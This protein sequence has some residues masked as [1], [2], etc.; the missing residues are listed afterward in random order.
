MATQFNDEHPENARSFIYVT[1]LGIFI[2]FKLVQYIN[3]PISIDYTV[4]GISI[5]YKL[6]HPLNIA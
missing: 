4:F 6:E 1:E 5:Y 2:D 3:A